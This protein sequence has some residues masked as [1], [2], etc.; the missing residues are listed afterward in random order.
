MYFPVSSEFYDAT[1][2]KHGNTY[3]MKQMDSTLAKD[4]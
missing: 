2:P 3:D 4:L 1:S